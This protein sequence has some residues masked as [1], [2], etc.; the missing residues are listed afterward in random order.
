MAPEPKDRPATAR[1]AALETFAVRRASAT[2]VICTGLRDDL[3]ARGIDAAKIMVSPNGV[4]LTVFGD[5]LPRDDALAAELCLADETIGF[6][7]SFYDYEG[8]DDLIAAMPA[9]VARRPNLKLVLVGGGPDGR[10][11]AR[12]GRCV[13]GVERDPLRRPSRARRGR[14]LLQRDRRAGVSA[15]SHTADRSGHAA[16][17]DRG[18]GATQPGRPRRTSADIAN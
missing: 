7:G 10:R 17:A 14:A 15:Q 3:V 11:L 18:D 9:L 4:D 8:L 13:A 12:A 1:L 2:A 6:I 5:P 16:Q